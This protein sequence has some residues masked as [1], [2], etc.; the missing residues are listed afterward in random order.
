MYKHKTGKPRNLIPSCNRQRQKIMDAFKKQLAN[1][2]LILLALF[3][4][5]MLGGGNYE[6][7]NV[8]TVVASAP[9][10]SFAMMQGSYGFNPVKFWVTF[11]PLTIL[12]FLVAIISNWSFTTE[13]RNL[14]L[15][16][17]ALDAVVILATFLYFAPA[18]EVFVSATYQENHIDEALL[19][20]AQRWKN[21]NIFRLVTIY[22]S[23]S[24]L[25]IALT[26][27][28]LSSKSS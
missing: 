12:L 23:S 28:N 20:N 18:T 10:G 17:F 4:L 11:R 5:I 13:R 27:T 16:A 26:K 6:H 15:T 3:Y 22:I 7:M 9:P 8:T 2:S 1:I 19:K 25:L 24:L 14:L 21:L